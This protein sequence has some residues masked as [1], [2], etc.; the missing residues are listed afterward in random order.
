MP[1]YRKTEQVSMGEA[2]EV[3]EEQM[4][5]VGDLVRWFSPAGP[6]LNRKVLAIGPKRFKLGDAFPGIR[7]IP[8]NSV[9]FAYFF[10][11]HKQPCRRCDDH[12][13]TQYPFGYEG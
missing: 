5:H 10:E 11:T 8:N 9:D 12:P 6:C 2:P 7:R 1:L 13:K 4:I 3:I